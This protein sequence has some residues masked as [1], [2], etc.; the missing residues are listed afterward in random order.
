MSR[1]GGEP[2]SRE[3]ADSRECSSMGQAAVPEGGEFC[4]RKIL[5]GMDDLVGVVGG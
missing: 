3:K 1:R 2:G 5:P 4:R